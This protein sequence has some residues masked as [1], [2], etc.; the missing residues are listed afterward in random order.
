MD[1][2]GY[3]Y[4]KSR[5]KD[6]V[7]RG[8]TNIYPAEVESF[9]RTH[10]NVIDCQVVGVPD[11]RVGEELY[12]WIKLKPN[13]KLTLDEL[14]QFCSG[15]IAHFKVPR[16]MKIVNSFPINPNGKVLKNKIAEMARKDLNL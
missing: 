16:Y 7:I 4:F 12:A 6:I 9:I 10:S 2:D 15:K 3:L 14:K 13:T 5:S 11:A 8:G 1:E